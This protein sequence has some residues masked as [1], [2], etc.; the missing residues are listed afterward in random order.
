MQLWNIATDHPNPAGRP[1]AG[2][3]GGTNSVAFSPNSKILA[4]GSDNGD[5]DGTV[6]LW[7]TITRQKMGSPISSDTGGFDS[8]AFSPNGSTLATGDG[9]GTV[10]LWNVARATGLLPAGSLFAYGNSE[11]GLT[12]FSPNGTTLATVSQAATTVAARSSCGT[13]PPATPLRSAALS[14]TAR[15]ETIL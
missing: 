1:F 3:D 4:T 7:N 5:G 15:R 12:A 2:A 9:D 11:G 14:P 10:Q 8:V 13:W 6:Q